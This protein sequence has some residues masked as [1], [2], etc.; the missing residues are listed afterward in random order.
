MVIYTCSNCYKKFNQKC[1]YDSHINRK[2]KCV[3][4][5]AKENEDKHELSETIKG[6][7]EK[8][9]TIVTKIEKL[10]RKMMHLNMNWKL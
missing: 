7:L 4:I 9:D 8:M 10:E 2:Y 3:K 5:I 1:N 6:L